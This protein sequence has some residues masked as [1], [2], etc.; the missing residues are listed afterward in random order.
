MLLL[1]LKAAT[2]E[3]LRKSFCL[4]ELLY[5]RN[6]SALANV[7]ECLNANMCLN[8]LSASIKMFGHD[9]CRYTD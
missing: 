9:L 3:N 6:Y 7:Y 1:L 4:R 5:L 8:V 2:G